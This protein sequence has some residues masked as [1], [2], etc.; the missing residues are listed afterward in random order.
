MRRSA[1]LLAVAAALVPAS[2]ALGMDMS[3]DMGDGAPPA[4][5]IGISFAAFA[6]PHVDVVAGETVRWSNDSTRAHDIVAADGSFD[7]G[8]VTVGMTYTHRFAVAGAV[9]YY[10]SLHPFMTGEVDVHDV[11]LD[12]PG[13]RGGSGKP[14]VLSGRVAAGITSSVTIEGDD[15]GGFSPV[16]TAAVGTD[17]TFRTTVVPR[18]TTRY[19]AQAGG[20]TSPAVQLLVLDHTLAVATVGRHGGTTVVSVR[21]TPAA[22]GQTVVL[23]ERL[24][25]RF[26]WWPVSTVKLDAHSA[27]RFVVGRRSKVPARVLLT[28]RDGATELARSA[29]V[30]VGLA[31]RRHA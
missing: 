23:Q 19:R 25:E 14:Y 21:V 7:S 15:G 24:H 26:G 9:P 18:T 4:A 22:P 11:V 29:T 28:L 16:T 17:G 10:C 13:Q 30:H 6:T 20:D 12:A 3:M 31:H 8:R 1:A 5:S 27:A 2:A